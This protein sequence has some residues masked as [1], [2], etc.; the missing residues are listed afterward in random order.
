M[1]ALGFSQMEIQVT[2]LYNKIQ[3]RETDYFVTI[4]PSHR[5]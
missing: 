5:Y 3:V 2:E 1:K 4:F